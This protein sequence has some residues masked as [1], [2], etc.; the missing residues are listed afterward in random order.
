MTVTLQELLDNPKLIEKI[1]GPQTICSQC[2][3]RLGLNDERYHSDKGLVCGDC[4]Y[5]QEVDAKS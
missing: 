3:C 2:K 1:Q 4:Y 5:S